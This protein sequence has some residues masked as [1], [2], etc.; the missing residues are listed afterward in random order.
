MREEDILFDLDNYN[1]AKKESRWFIT[2]DGF[3]E[4]QSEVHKSYLRLLSN[5]LILRLMYV[6]SITK[7]K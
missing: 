4:N 2:Y 3:I 7:K 6:P 1:T 5:S